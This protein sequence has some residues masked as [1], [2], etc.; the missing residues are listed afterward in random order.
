M[1]MSGRWRRRSG[2]LT[3]LFD[4][5]ILT[6]TLNAIEIVGIYATQREE[7]NGDTQTRYHRHSRRAGEP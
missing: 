1:S 3:I 2:S 7:Q 5:D 4:R 6:N